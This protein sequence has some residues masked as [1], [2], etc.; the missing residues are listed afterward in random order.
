M[1]G[2]AVRLSEQ[3]KVKLEAAGSWRWHRWAPMGAGVGVGGQ[4]AG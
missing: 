2:E 3:P 4:D 1:P